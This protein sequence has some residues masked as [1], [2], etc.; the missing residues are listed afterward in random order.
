LPL[1]GDE[2]A[3]VVSLLRQLD[4]LRGELADADRAIAQQALGDLAVQITR[5][6][7]TSQSRNGMNSLRALRQSLLIGGYCPPH[8][9]SNSSKRS[10]AAA[11][12]GAV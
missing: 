10:R 9:A 2:R 7:S 3:S 8:F 11:S 12:A 6:I 1:P 5:R 4:F